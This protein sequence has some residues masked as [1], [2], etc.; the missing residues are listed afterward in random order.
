M[1]KIFAQ[2]VR[3]GGGVPLLNYIIEELDKREIQ[4]DIHH[5]TS[6][7]ATK[8]KYIKCYEYKHGFS[9]I[10]SFLPRGKNTLF[11]GNLPPL[12]KFQ[13]SYVFFHNPYISLPY[14][15]LLKQRPKLLI[16]YFLQRLYIRYFG[17][18]VSGFICQT[19]E[20]QNQVEK[21]VTVPVYVLPIFEDIKTLKLTSFS[22]SLDLFYPAY[23]HTHKNHVNL[24][25]A[26][27]VLETRNISL[28]IGLTLPPNV[29]AL[30]QMF[31]EFDTSKYITI[32]NYG[33]IP[34][35]DVLSILQSARA[36]IFPSLRETLGLPLIEAAQLGKPIIAPHLSYIDQIVEPSLRFD[37][38]NHRSIAKAIEQ[39]ITQKNVKPAKLKIQDETSQLI[40]LLILENT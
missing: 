9:K 20:I 18:N 6:F 23:P 2:N 17:K 39:F 32:C 19:S 11:F 24:Y 25:K 8:T 15:E 5:D 14:D 28:T 35:I 4:T 21:I 30:L 26:L 27:K 34:K 7:H 1:L 10:L 13:N 3:G 33:I 22:P 37:P 31:S 29:E 16:K 36:L 38:E 40:N 12:R